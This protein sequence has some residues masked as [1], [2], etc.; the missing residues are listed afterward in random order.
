MDSAPSKSPVP[1]AA[2]RSTVH[3]HRN[4]QQCTGVGQQPLAPLINVSRWDRP[5]IPSANFSG[6]R[7]SAENSRQSLQSSGTMRIGPRPPARRKPRRRIGRRHP[8]SRAQLSCHLPS[9]SSQADA[10]VPIIGNSGTPLRPFV[11]APATWDYSQ[12]LNKDLARSRSSR[13][14]VSAIIPSKG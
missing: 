9:P 5:L 4:Q 3:G 6:W 8:Q 14:A 7:P 1:A 2:Y 11:N 10:P 13:S 12:I